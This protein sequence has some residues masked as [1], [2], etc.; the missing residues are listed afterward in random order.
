MA[1]TKKVIEET[2]D[3]ETTVVKVAVLT[4]DIKHINE[5]L[6]RLEGKFDGAIQSFVTTGQLQQFQSEA[7]RKHRE[8]EQMFENLFSD[9]KA[10]RKTDDLQQGALDNSRR[11]LAVG[12]TV[13]GIMVTAVS[14]YLGV[15]R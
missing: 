9:V 12:L 2:P 1:T 11:L 3:G 13:I 7:D 8:Y 6:T 14:I 5:T 15:H 10:L 4:N